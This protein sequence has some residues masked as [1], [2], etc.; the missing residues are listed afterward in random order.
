MRASVKAVEIDIIAS[1]GGQSD[2]PTPSETSQLLGAYYRPFCLL[3][4]LTFRTHSF[5]RSWNGPNFPC[6]EMWS[7]VSYVRRLNKLFSLD[8]GG[9]GT[10][11]AEYLQYEVTSHK[12]S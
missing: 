7:T 10:I 6:S 1:S 8:L 4:S 3:L 11:P 2:E 9:E 5:I 12:A